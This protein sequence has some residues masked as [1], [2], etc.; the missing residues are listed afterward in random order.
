[1]PALRMKRMLEDTDFANE[2][3]T[4]TVKSMK[5]SHFHVSEL[6]QSA[7]LNSPDKVPQDDSDPTIQL[8]DQDIRVMEASG[9]HDLHGG[10]SVGVFKDLTSGV[11]VSP[12]SE[13]DSSANYDD[14]ESLL[15]IVNYV[16]KEFAD[17]G[18]DYSAQSFCAVSDHEASWGPN[19]C[20][21]LLDIYSPDGDFHFLLDN[22][23]DLLPSYTG[24]CEEFVSIDAFMNASSRCG[25]FPLIESVTEASIDNKPCSPEVDLCF[26]N[27][28]VLEWLNPHLSEEDLPDLVDFAELNSN[29]IPATKEQGTRKVTLVLDLDETLVH[30]TMEQCDDAD[31]T[32]PVF[33]DMKEHVVYV[34]KRPHVDMFLQKMVEMFDVVIFTASQSV[35]ANQLLD[36]LDP[37]NKLFSKR[38]FRES[39]LFTDSSY[40]KD[41]TV[42][43]VDLAKVAIIDNTP[44][45]FQLQ[46]NNGI[47][48][49]SWYNNPADE[50][51]PQ[52]IPFLETLAVAD[53]VRPIIAKKFGNI[54]DSC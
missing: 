8:A 15:H 52:L 54:I 47:P 35:Y 49:E 27:S 36:M 33:C 40:T 21:S 11:V 32:F 24:L 7:V 31:F 42:V 28:D 20:C 48:I 34:K 16:D 17:E 23:A 22:P 10:K 18:V 13:A 38:F 39:C 44:Q 12:N 4:K 43:G 30:S 37:E 2:F 50:A 1:M 53:D 19:Q 5:I 6:E 29:A 3:N 45:V 26:S 25:S 46:V 51:L 41:L 14:D 9:L